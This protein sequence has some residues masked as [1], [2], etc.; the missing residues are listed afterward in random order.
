MCDKFLFYIAI[1]VL[2]L[3][4]LNKIVIETFDGSI[5][6]TNVQNAV[7]NMSKKVVNIFNKEECNINKPCANYN[8]CINGKCV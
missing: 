6:L 7:N 4:T 5:M 8:K 1:I 3:L 2:L